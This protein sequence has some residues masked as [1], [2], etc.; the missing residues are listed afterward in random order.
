MISA[1]AGDAAGFNAGDSRLLA[2]ALAAA[3][4]ILSLLSYARVASFGFVNYDDNDYVYEN[5]FVADGLTAADL[6]A[7][8]SGHAA[9]WHPATWWSHMLDVELFGLEAGRHHVVNVSLHVANSL[10]LFLLLRGATGATWRS[11]LVAALFALHP[12]NVETV[13]WI[14][15]RK[16]L[17]STLTW[18]LSIAAYARWVRT[19][20]GRDYALLVLLFA[21]GLMSKPMIVTL[22]LTLLVLD[23]WPLRRIDLGEFRPTAVTS[24]IVEK[25]PLFCM[26]GAT[27]IVT[28]VV[29]SQWKA[30]ST[31]DA[32]PFGARALNAVVSLGWY[33]LKAVVPTN[34]AVFYP[35]PSI[36]GSTVSAIEIAASAFV[37]ALLV[38]VAFRER[39][40][41]PFLAAGV[42]WYVITL[43]PVLGLIQVGLQAH[44]DR[45]AYV[46]L[47]GVFVAA[48]WLLPDSMSRRSMQITAVIGAALVL[49]CAVATKRQVN[50]WRDSGT[51]FQ[52]ALDVTGGDN[53][54]AKRNLAAY[55]TEIGLNLKQRGHVNEALEYFRTAAK[56]FPSADALY[57]EAA[58]LTDLERFEEAI[59]LYRKSLSVDRAKAD[60]WLNLGD[61]LVMTRDY[62]AAVDAYRQCLRIRPE[63]YAEYGLAFAAAKIGDGL[64][65]QQAVERLRVTDPLLARELERQ[66]R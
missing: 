16:S 21:L 11:A 62:G 48:T 65:A 45:Y 43:V 60:A 12:L 6:A 55:Y 34:L 5:S 26:S 28:Y 2:A 27:A 58:M 8:F 13:A 7:S 66:L 15:E 56:T 42:G 51:L 23:V 59:P 22:P 20:S 30:V 9:N 1:S 25:L 3:I 35:H 39:T 44:A 18:L 37:V 36:V 33:L 46:P 57:N 64:T 47:I 54:V 41:R 14:S 10:L 4:A 61:A 52:R 17:L 50:T 31:A 63:K 24:L 40:R 32:I 29:Q 53:P 19:R 38:F 49:S